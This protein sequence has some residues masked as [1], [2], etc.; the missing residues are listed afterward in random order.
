MA[1]GGGYW[2]SQNKILPGSYVNFVSA[3]NASASLSERG[4]ATIGLAL[5]WCPDGTVFKV[6]SADVVRYSV[7]YF[8]HNYSDAAM[9]PVREIFKHATTVYFYN[10]N[11][12]G[13]KA[14][15]TYGTAKYTGT[16][17]NAITI[18]IETTTDSKFEV[19]TLLNGV[20]VDS[21]V[22]TSAAELEGNAFVDFDTTATLEATAG[23]TMTGG[24]DGTATAA[25]HSAYLAAIE[26]YT[27]NTI[28][29]ASTDAQIIALYVAFARRMREDVG[30]K[31]QLVYPGRGAEAVLADY[32]GCIRIA[33][34]NPENVNLVPWLTGAEAGCKVN[35][36]LTNFTYDGELTIDVDLSQRDL[37]DAVL[38][39]ALVFHKVGDTIRVLRD[40][41]TLTTY[42][43]EKNKDFS[44]NQTI[45]VLDQ[46][47]NDIAVK[48]NDKYLG[49]VP[50]DTAGRTSLW[51]DIVNLM[52]ELG[53][54][55]ALEDFEPSNVVVSR[56]QTKTDVVVDCWITPVNCMEKLYMTVYVM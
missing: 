48:F 38:T 18:V 3:A 50:N 23:V 31:F 1:L 7:E 54:I 51:S 24:T 46:I 5:D 14:S 6:T 8:G 19:I 25:S 37:E 29:C 26:S 41:N 39:G 52:N 56:G 40:I 4:T 34:N 32:E 30:A 15:C 33:N 10:L 13:V 11:T 16:R 17:G 45:R 27:F 9:L 53:R 36:S 28:G 21:Q 35:A 12:G 2:T 47:G 20:E 22:V 43:E 55:R 44:H 49:K 42:T